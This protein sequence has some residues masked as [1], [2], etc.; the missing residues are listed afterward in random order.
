MTYRGRVQNGV[1]VFD[2]PN[3][4]AEGTEVTAQ[5]LQ[6][7]RKP[8]TSKKPRKGVRPGIMEFAGKAKDLPADASRNV[9]HYLY[10]HA[11]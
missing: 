5:P 4:L 10:G 6:R 3:N 7:K 2:D 9:D 8:P 11:T 1:V